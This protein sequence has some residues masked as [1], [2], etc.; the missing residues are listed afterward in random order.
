MLTQL[1]YTKEEM[2]DLI[3]I[4]ADVRKASVSY[5]QVLDKQAST[6]AKNATRLDKIMLKTDWFFYKIDA[7]LSKA[8]SEYNDAVFANNAQSRKTEGYIAAAERSGMDTTGLSA[9]LAAQQEQANRD[10]VNIQAAYAAKLQEQLD[11][12]TN[13]D[14]FKNAQ[15]NYEDAEAA[16]KNADQNNV[17]QLASLKQKYDAAANT[18][19]KMES[20]Q[21]D[22][23]S[24][25]DDINEN[26]EK[27]NAE[28]EY[29][30]KYRKYTTSEKI[31]EGASGA[32][33]AWQVNNR[34][35]TSETWLTS[36]SSEM[37]TSALETATD[38]AQTLFKTILDGTDSAS[39]A[40][41]SFGR[42]V[43][44]AMRDIAVKYAA[45]AAM[46]ALFGGA[47]DST[48]SSSSSGLVQA[49]WTALKTWAMSA[50]GGVVVGPEKN[51]DSVLT[52]L[53][54]GEYVLKKSA[55][56]AIGQDYLDQLNT[57]TGSTISSSTSD[58]EAARGNT[59]NGGNTGV[60]G[61]VNVYVVSQQEQ[62]AMTPNDVIVTITQ[63]MIKGGQ[64]KK[65]VKQISMGA[66]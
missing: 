47:S 65:L 40:F 45:N 66:I 2:A 39:N 8:K 32:L 37:T 18:W 31:T 23:K 34:K 3:P 11:K 20:K 28:Q 27:S 14:L 17:T 55:V 33:N 46:Q 49:G 50:Q 29:L 7:E 56:D 61:T 57:N 22:I 64:T 53:M 63:D 4:L 36:L 24:K 38:Q 21:T 43:I 5:N 25:L 13:S 12:L 54:P 19:K 44:E 15:K 51:R 52:K 60:G 58:L 35:Y 59:E 6:M 42:A 30:E 41:K 10:L 62:Q 1:D 48:Q 26:I 16:Y 9:T